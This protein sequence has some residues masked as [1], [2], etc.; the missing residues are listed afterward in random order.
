MAY[1][2]KPVFGF[3]EL[4]LV[5]LYEIESESCFLQPQLNYSLGNAVSLEFGGTLMELGDDGYSTLFSQLIGERLYAR[6][7]VD[8]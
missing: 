1:M 2:T 3:H 5:A 6:L 7:A 4:E 8:F